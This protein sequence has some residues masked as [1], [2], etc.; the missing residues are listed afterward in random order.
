MKRW[1]IKLLHRLLI[2]TVLAVI[3]L[4]LQVV[5]L[6]RLV[7][8]RILSRLA[9]IGLP[10]ATLEVRS[11]SWRG[12]ELANVNLDKDRCGCIG[13]VA[14]QYSPRS[15]IQGKLKKVQIT[16]GQLLLRVRDGKVEMGELA[17][18][19][20][21]NGEEAVDHPFGLIELHSCVLSIDLEK[22]RI[23]IPCDGSIVNTGDG[24]LESDLNLNLQGVPL[25]V[26]LI[27][28]SDERSLSFSMEKEDLDLRAL[29]TALPTGEFDLPARL[30]GRIDVKLEGEISGN[31]GLAVFSLTAGNGWL[32]TALANSPVDV[33]GIEC[34]LHV[35]LKD[36]SQLEKLSCDLTADA[37][38]Y[39][40]V[41]ANEMHFSL[42]KME[43]GFALFGEAKGEEWQ[44]KE[45]SGILPAGLCPKDE[46]SQV[47]ISWELE[48]YVPKGVSEKISD[49][50]LDISQLGAISISGHLLTNM[51][52]LPGRALPDFEIPELQVVLAPGELKMGQPEVVLREFS[53][54]VRLRGSCKNAWSEFYVLPGSGLEFGSASAGNLMIEKTKL[55]LQG[56]KDRSAVESVFDEDNLKTRICLEANSDGMTV[57]VV[58]D[59]L[60][61]KVDGARLSVDASLGS[62]P[63]TATGTLA[64]DGL[65]CQLG[66]SGLLLVLEGAVLNAELNPSGDAG[67]V[68][69]AMLTLDTATLLNGKSEALFAL[70]RDTLKPISGS[71]DLK[72]REGRVQLQWPIQK[73]A[74]L[75]ANGYIDLQEKQPSGFCSVACDGFRIEEE[76]TAIKMLAN[77]TGLTVSGDFS[78]K[79]N[80]RL[81]RGHLVPR[82]TIAAT[83]TTLSS[84]R[85]Q[86]QAEGINGAM[87]ITGFSPIS[88][89]GN[90][91]FEVQSF[92]L[93]KLQLQDGF[94]ALCF[95]DDPPALL[96][97]RAEWGCLG[98]RV[99]SRALRIDPNQPEIDIRLF[100][101]GLD[102]DKLF[103]LAFGQG[104]TGK[105]T[106]Y[107][108]IPASVSRSN[109]ADFTIGEGFLHATNGNGSWKLG[110]S[111]PANIV[112]KALEQQL[113]KMLQ[114]SVEVSIQ[115]KIFR[116]LR[117]F[118]YSMF[119]IDFLRQKDG[120]LARVTTRGRSRDPRVPVE[121]EEI[122]L[123]FPGFDENLRKI[124]VIRTAVG[125]GLKRTTDKLER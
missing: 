16:G 93:G 63:G 90:Q 60:M 15:L 32:K 29:M 24:R 65:E 20:L 100:A 7:R 48:G 77:S 118:E 114:E 39:G 10:E 34:Q 37:V 78:L 67:A 86:A 6:P 92:K 102:M 1:P 91:R 110:D 125:Q 57:Q 23:C 28:F 40:Y 56:T 71:L 123:D 44:L 5:V 96:I 76:Q 72:Q 95:E 51:S 2:F 94:I 73:E 33:E 82:V 111:D 116:G 38:R 27:S 115:D 47:K 81:E 31:D 53:G 3:M 108:M 14:V 54:V 101:N 43:E 83:D 49:K 97:E 26:R 45:L 17:K 124:M 61:A 42:E 99:Y 112:Q 88:T 87:T 105:G 122:V 121:F 66:S 4:L 36:K 58:K 55:A 89:P 104:G 68:L 11:C 41:I 30:A 21:G 106:L 70:D 120:I 8:H 107:G 13:A 12:A 109:L 69:E 75:Y 59:M 80:L 117:D 22:K 113:G 85:Y 25:H 103:G 50:G 46:G 84:K 119:K 52:R 35:D 19:K 64:I 79:G 98:G 9:E 62:E 18:L 74:I